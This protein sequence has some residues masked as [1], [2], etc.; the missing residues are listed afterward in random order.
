MF[1]DLI[2]SIALLLT[3]IMTPLTL[4]FS[5]ELEKVHWYMILS[6][7]IDGLF[8]IDIFVNFNAAFFQEEYILVT[9]RKEIACNYLKGWFAVD[10][11]SVLP[12]DLMSASP[13]DDSAV[14]S[15]VAD[16]AAASNNSTA[17]AVI[18]N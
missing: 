6:Y 7:T 14:S 8:V 3:C 18:L 15:F 2:V 5:D 10:F 4:A 17:S 12:L 1:W 9:D 13:S 11:I 16:T